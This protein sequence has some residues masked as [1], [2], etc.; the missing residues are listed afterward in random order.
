MPT[1]LLDTNVLLY[2]ANKAAPEHQL[3]KHAITGMLASGDRLAIAPQVLYEFW[4]VATRPA[5]VNGLGWTV[6]ETRTA[7]DGF[8]GRYLL[9]DEPPGVVDLWL[10]LVTVHQLQGKRV[11]DAHLL[12]TMKANSV[13]RLLTFN[14]GDFPARADVTIVVPG[15]VV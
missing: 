13:D 4:S 3:A 9:L 10:D 6:L 2:L 8:R 11:H 7:V 12:A 15:V 14:P 1:C 5:S